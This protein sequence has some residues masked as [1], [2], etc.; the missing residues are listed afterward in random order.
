MT[1]EFTVVCRDDLAGHWDIY[2]PQSGRV[3]A[4]RGNAGAYI[5][6]DERMTKKFQGTH[7]HF[8]TANSA[9]AFI[10]LELMG[11]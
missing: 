4:I 5:I 10:C 8:D 6:R 11:K 9:I 3:F 2:T 1:K 7:N